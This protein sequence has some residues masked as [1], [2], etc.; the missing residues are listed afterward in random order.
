MPSRHDAS[1]V[2]FL[3]YGTGF[4]GRQG[5]SSLVTAIASFNMPTPHPAV[6]YT[7]GPARGRGSKK[8]AVPSTRSTLLAPQKTRRRLFVLSLVVCHLLMHFLFIS[9]KVACR[10]P[11]RRVEQLINVRVVK[12]RKSSEN[13]MPSD[14]AITIFPYSGGVG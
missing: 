3:G 1:G 13:K 7:R 12:P 6:V 5:G 9:P 8:Q 14:A 10:A 2:G 11:L 4:G